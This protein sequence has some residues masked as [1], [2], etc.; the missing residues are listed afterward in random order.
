MPRFAPRRPSTARA[1]ASA[2]PR[3]RFRPRPADVAAADAPGRVAVPAQRPFAPP[4][5]PPE[6]AGTGGAQP[7]A[8]PSTATASRGVVASGG[9]GEARRAPGC[10][11]LDARLP[12]KPD[13]AR[14]RGDA[15]R[16]ERLCAITNKAL[17]H[18]RTR[19][20]SFPSAAAE[21]S[22][23]SPPTPGS[24]ASAVDV[25]RTPRSRTPSRPRA[26][27]EDGGARGARRGA[28]FRNALGQTSPSCTARCG[29]GHLRG[30]HG[31]LSL[32]V[33]PRD[34]ASKPADGLA[35]PRA[36][37]PPLPPIHRRRRRRR[38]LPGSRTPLEVRLRQ[39]PQL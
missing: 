4:P 23:R 21:V 14:P 5:A 35:N 36:A 2:G 32:E 26:R 11:Q 1:V 18:W 17:I 7:R 15:R 19:T 22:G 12:R 9:S 38:T 27:S 24:P 37:S 34:A 25:A 33:Q 39:G 6:R 29:R 30:R 8:P 31:A 20:R 10:G 28:T 16:F 3:S 13:V